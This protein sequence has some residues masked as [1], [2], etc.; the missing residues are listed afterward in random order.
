MKLSCETNELQKAV[1][2]VT[3]G[4]SAR[5]T[6][7][8]LTGIM[9]DAKK[10][11]I[12]L[13][14]TDL[15]IS[16]RMTIESKVGEEGK[17]V[18]PAKL[19]GDIVRSLDDESVQMTSE[20]YDATIRSGSGNFKIRTFPSEDFPKP[21][22]IG[23]GGLSINRDIIND[24][25][26][27]V[28]KA[29]S[30]D[31]TRPVLTGVLVDVNENQIKMVATDS[32]RL[33]IREEKI[34]SPN[35]EKFSAIVPGRALLEL[36]RILPM[37]EKEEV[38]I[39]PQENQVLFD[40]G[41]IALVSRLIEGQFPNYQ[42]LL[43][44]RHEIEI[45]LE[46]E[47][48]NAIVKRVSILAQNNLPIKMIFDKKSLVVSSDTQGVGQAEEKLTIEYEGEPLEVAFNPGYLLDGL[49]SLSDKAIKMN[50]ISSVKPAVL[51]GEKAENFIYLLMPVRIG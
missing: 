2:I 14:S 39:I 7:P 42:Q 36:S 26:I 29:A 50:F 10:D 9:I 44:E 30:R 35:K 16:L 28:S 1:Q 23:D 49:N 24:M 41:N 25:V 38:N 47:A 46:R 32:Y 43:P 34:V 5:T 27:K 20:G 17:A 31:E 13:M 8:I 4:V 37:V 21:P 18:L 15:E 11:E 40:L 22:D 48:L 12:E 33:A 45:S 51:T 3:R 6:L 19:F